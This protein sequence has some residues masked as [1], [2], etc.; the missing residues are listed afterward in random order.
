M[1]MRCKAFC[2]NGFRRDDIRIRT[3]LDVYNDGRPYAKEEHPLEWA[4]PRVWPS[5]VEHLARGTD[6][7][8]G[9]WQ[10]VK[11]A[12]DTAVQISAWTNRKTAGCL[13]G[14][15]GSQVFAEY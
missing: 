14:V 2:L 9:L 10:A 13:S 8:K 6:V 7:V 4:F 12:T 11:R 3:R 5:F 1:A 15:S